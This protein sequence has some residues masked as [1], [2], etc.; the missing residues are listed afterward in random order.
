MSDL[1]D[2]E[3]PGEL[4]TYLRITHRIAPADAISIRPLAGGISNRTVLVRRS[5]GE[6]WV[7]K[8]ALPKLRVAVDWFSDPVRIEREAI[9]MQWLG[10]LAPPQTIP[11]FIFEDRQCH[12]VAM[13][14]VPEPHENWKAVL[15][16]GRLDRRRRAAICPAFGNYPPRSAPAT[17][18][19]APIFAN[20]DFFESL[21]LEPYYT[22]TAARVPAA[23]VFLDALTRDTRQIGDTLVH[24]DYS[25]RTSSF[26]P[27]AWCCWIT[28]WST[29]ATR[30]STWVFR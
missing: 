3:R 26:T 12:L 11:R 6:P 21:R 27:I 20:R 13:E 1:L 28:K 23:A 30:P 9:G 8:Q 4:E 14:A 7:V 17:W 5:A 25:P 22:F 15:L 2:I 29:G 19:L 24:G 16:A 10:E 18:R